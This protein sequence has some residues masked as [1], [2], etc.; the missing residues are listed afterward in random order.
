[1]KAR[2]NHQ[3]THHGG[4][5]F[6]GFLAQEGIREDVES[7]LSLL[8]FV[9][10]FF[11]LLL[12]H[13]L[14][15][16]WTSMILRVQF[17]IFYWNRQK[18]IYLFLPEYILGY[19]LFLTFI[20]PIICTCVTSLGKRVAAPNADSHRIATASHPVDN[21]QNGYTASDIRAGSKL[22]LIALQVRNSTGRPIAPAAHPVA[23]AL[24]RNQGSGTFS[25]D[26][27]ASFDSLSVGASG[28]SYSLVSSSPG[29]TSA[30]GRPFNV[31]GRNAVGTQLAIPASLFGLTVL[32]FPN[33]S[34]SMRFGT[35][36]SWDADSLD[37]SDVNPSLGVY[38]FA[39]LDT[40][41]AINKV[42]G[43]DIIYTLGRTPRWASSQPSAPGPYG[44][45]QCAPPTDMTAW[46]NYVRAIATHAAGQIKN[47]ELWN[48]AQ[49]TRFYCGDILTMV[50]MARHAS[51]II[52]GIDPSALILSPAVTGPQGPTWLA[53]FLSGG[54]AAYTDVIAFHGYWSATAEDAISVVSRYKTAAAA[55]GAAGKPIWDTES[56][57]AGFGNLGTPNKSQQVGFVAK[58][59]LLHWSQGISRLVWYAYDGG[60]I[61]GGL[62]AA[63]AGESPAAES[64]KETYRWMVGA[65]LATP[66]AAGKMGFWTCTLSRIGGYTA[67]VVWIPKV[68]ASFA[69]PAQYT[70][71]RDLTGA[72]YTI[73]NHTITV[74]DQPILLE[75]T[76]LS[77]EAD[78]WRD[79]GRAASFPNAVSVVLHHAAKTRTRDREIAAELTN[80]LAK[81]AGESSTEQHEGGGPQSYADESSAEQGG[82]DEFEIASYGP[83]SPTGYI[84]P[85]PPFFRRLGQPIVSLV[86]KPSGSVDILEKR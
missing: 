39:G 60:P 73:T 70:V 19:V 59:Y 61:W 68:T 82:G 50:M 80:T 35:T 4:S 66:C 57:W 71:Y 9:T 86:Y 72:V 55:N 12:F 69:V 51:Q 52:K 38:N 10:S 84:E 42:R 45:G 3:L 26:G 63:G 85:N 6:D 16:I 28:T 76:D 18:K 1:M 78:S 34:P 36:R 54:G 17:C 49:D 47:W 62:W 81:A 65:S 25:I 43:S 58:D 21:A 53:S 7:R 2:T 64:Y 13:K 67:E 29:P 41:I 74:G 33:R 48:E 56:S 11:G 8:S 46:D 5:T 83:P 40:F 14:N 24:I 37:W 75:T 77:S 44:P 32:N 30:T 15:R 23:L 79:R 27:L 22:P 20:C 31:G